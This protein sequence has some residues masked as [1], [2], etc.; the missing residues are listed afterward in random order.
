MQVSSSGDV[1]VDCVSAD[2]LQ[3]TCSALQ[4]PLASVHCSAQCCIEVPCGMPLP[5]P[6]RPMCGGT[7]VQVGDTGQDAYVAA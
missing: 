7:V 2:L 3:L 6:S 1:T 4:Q 5:R